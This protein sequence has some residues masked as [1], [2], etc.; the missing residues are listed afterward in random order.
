M[1][2][3]RLARDL[4]R[5]RVDQGAITVSADPECPAGCTERLLEVGSSVRPA[6]SVRRLWRA[7]HGSDGRAGGRPVKASEL[8]GRAVLVLS[9]AA[10]VGHVDDILFDAPYRRVLG[11]RVKRGGLFGPREAV[12]RER[13]S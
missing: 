2:Y 10:K 11:F 8:N 12:S 3:L 6:M 5:A 7:I 4:H 9:Q 13:V 1:P